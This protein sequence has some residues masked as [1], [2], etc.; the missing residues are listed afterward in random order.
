MDLK[1]KYKIIPNKY[2]SKT[3][4]SQEALGSLR[5]DYGEFVLDSV[6]RKSEDINISAKKQEPVVCFCNKNSSAFEDINDLV[7][8]IIKNN[9]I[10][11]E[12]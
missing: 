2:E 10:E 5:Y 6:I 12:H 11:L 8:E 7:W 4:T 1:I 9:T 3:V